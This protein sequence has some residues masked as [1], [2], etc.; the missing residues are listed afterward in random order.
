MHGHCYQKALSTTKPILEILR[1]PEN[2]EVSEL[3]TGCCG[4]AGAFG[5]EKEHYELSMQVGSLKLF[6][7]IKAT[8]D[9]SKIAASGTSCRQQI[10]DGTGRLAYHPVEIL[11]DALI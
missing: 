11:A 7:A 2:Y 3:P 1:I 10:K 5:Y 6:P 8:P 4:M 9:D